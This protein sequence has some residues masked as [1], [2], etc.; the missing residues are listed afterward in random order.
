VQAHV[1]GGGERGGSRGGVGQ[2][3]LDWREPWPTGAEVEGSREALLVERLRRLTV[4][5]LVVHEVAVEAR[6]DGV[7]V[8]LGE[9]ADGEELRTAGGGAKAAICDERVDVDIESK[10]VSKPLDDDEHAA[11]QASAAR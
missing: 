1:E 6:E 11:V 2:I 9:R 8:R 3:R 7:E 10:V 5:A 4:L